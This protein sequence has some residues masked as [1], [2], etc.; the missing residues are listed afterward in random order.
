MKRDVFLLILITFL[1]YFNSFGNGFVWDDLNNIVNNDSL[2]GPLGF[3]EI[4]LNPAAQI[5]YRPIPYLTIWLDWFFW[6]ENPL[7]YHLTNF[8]FHLACVSLIFLL[9]QRLT[10]SRRVSL[11]SALIFAVHPV[12]TEAVAYISGRSDV[13][14]GFFIFL[15]FWFYLDFL[16]SLEKRKSLYL[17][18]A[19]FSYL[20]ALFSKEVALMFPLVILFLSLY[21]AQSTKGRY[22][23]T[24][25]V[26]KKILVTS[27][28]LFAGSA[29]A[30]LIFRYLFVKL[31]PMHI[32]LGRWYLFPKIFLFYLRLLVFPFGLHMQHSLKENV[33]LLQMPLF[34]SALIFIGLIFAAVKFIKDRYLRFGLAW[35][36]FWILPFLGFLKFNSDMAE[37]WLYIGSFG[38]FLIAGKFLVQSNLLKNNKL[39]FFFIILFLCLLTIQRN[40]IWRDDIS[41]YQDTLKYLPNDPKLHYNFG[42]AYLRK[43]LLN[44]AAREYSIAIEGNPSY[45]YALNNLGLILERQGNTKAAQKYYRM[46]IASDPKLDAAKKNLLRLGFTSLAFAQDVYFDHSLYGEVLKEFV[47]GG[48]VDYAGLKSNPFLLEVYLEE[49]ARLDSGVFYSFTREEKI[50]LYLNVYNAFTLKVIV[51]HYPVKGIRDIYGAWDRFKVKIAGSEFTL[52]QIEHEILREE[53]KEPRIHFVLVCASK[54]CPKL[55]DEPFNGKDLNDQMERES[56]K[57]INDK[58]KVRLDKDGR[59]LYISSIFKWFRDD[60]GDVIKFVTKYLPK[61]DSQFIQKEKPSIKYLKYDWSLNE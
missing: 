25:T 27:N 48:K 22:S 57:F 17:C 36:T 54:G 8:A 20:V 29:I 42:N 19:L 1:V 59:L 32:S 5:F 61:D 43:G 21:F 4:F 24:R 44:A 11:V 31:Q 38:F 34:L 46:A 26:S 53:F 45:A 41:I 23:S 39:A 3:A 58:T 13:S 33:F 18:A 9:C 16:N 37:H 40:A 2:N 47:E 52:N 30:Y 35:F 49:V 55:A 6:K 15:S 14:C 56:R 50:A 10:Q 12:H 51:Q 7:G 28:I 60:F